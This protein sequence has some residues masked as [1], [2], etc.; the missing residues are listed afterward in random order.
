MTTGQAAGD[1][2]SQ[3]Q[4]HLNG[5]CAMFFN[6]AGALQ[7]D[8]A[9]SSTADEPVAESTAASRRHDVKAMALDIAQA[10]K[11]LDQLIVQLPS[12]SETEAQQLQ[13]LSRLKVGPQPTLK[14]QL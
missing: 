3:I 8:A 1:L 2:I 13:R 12:I 5:L 10:S 4:E 7:R 14:A 11:Q 6:Y 9:P